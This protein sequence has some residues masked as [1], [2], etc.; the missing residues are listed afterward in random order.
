MGSGFEPD[1]LSMSQSSGAADTVAEQSET[2]AERTVNYVF[3]VEVIVVGALT[4]DD[5]REIYQQVWTDFGEA[6]EYQSA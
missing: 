5:R 4:D 3:P 2:S 1:D 6:M